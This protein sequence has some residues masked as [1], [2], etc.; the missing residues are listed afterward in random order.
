[1]SW[2]KTFD[3]EQKKQKARKD[4][5]LSDSNGIRIYNHLVRKR[6]LNHVAKVAKRLNCVVSADKYSQNS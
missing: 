4:E 1:M 6:I 3:S 5:N 2:F